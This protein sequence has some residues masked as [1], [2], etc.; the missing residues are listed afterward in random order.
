MKQHGLRFAA[1]IT[2]TVACI[3]GCGDS[4][5]EPASQAQEVLAVDGSSPGLM[6]A[7]ARPVGV[8]GETGTFLVATNDGLVAVSPGGDVFNFGS[9]PASFRNVEVQG[10]RIFASGWSRITEYDLTGAIVSTID[11]PARIGYP[12]GF[13]A[14]PDG[15]FAIFDCRA[16]SVYFVD[17]T[18]AIVH[19]LEIPENLPNDNYQIMKGLVRDGRLIISETG[20]GKIIAIDLT[21]YDATIFRDFSS[22]FAWFGDI[23][24]KHPHYYVTRSQRLQ[25]FTEGG[26]LRDVAEFET[27]H[28]LTGIAI[29]GHHAY[30]SLNHVG[31]IRRI[32]LSSGRTDVIATGLNYP[33]DIEFIPVVLEPPIGP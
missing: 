29:L 31:E 25:R 19:E 15:G 1:L 18:G 12:I 26:R 8:G 3:L 28:N 32:H 23:N 27:A 9:D 33:L 10:T 13:T 30:G 6:G 11:L 2:F 14:L 16:D 22:E 20:T 5:L 7:S 24:Y 4:G 21:T 17:A